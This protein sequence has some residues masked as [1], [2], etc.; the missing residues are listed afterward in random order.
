MT[1]MDSLLFGIWS[2]IV[3]MTSYWIGYYI[4]GKQ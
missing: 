2:A 3:S 1:D 4:R